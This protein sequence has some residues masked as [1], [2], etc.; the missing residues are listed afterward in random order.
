M[1]SLHGTLLRLRTKSNIFAKHGYD[2]GKV[3]GFTPHVCD[4]GDSLPI[5]KSLYRVPVSQRAILDKEIEQMLQAGISE[6][7]PNSS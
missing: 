2:L 1:E 4:I 5:K 3:T 6:E 7:A